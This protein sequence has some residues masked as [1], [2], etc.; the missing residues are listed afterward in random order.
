MIRV[1]D[2]A[3]R[4]EEAAGLWDGALCGY[5]LRW[6]EV[7]GRVDPLACP[8]ARECFRSQAIKGV[9]MKRFAWMVSAVLGIVMSQGIAHAQSGPSSYGGTQS[10]WNIFNRKNKSLT[11]E[12][13]RLNKFWHD[14]YDALKQYYNALD[15]I[16]WVA[17]YKNHGYRSPAATTA[18]TGDLATSTTPPSW[19]LP[20]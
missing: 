17:Y 11:P 9:A 20:R 6:Q 7:A 4:W 2:A 19:W 1:P 15:H 8:V 12:E 13:Q 3:C 16:D 18:P 14:Y 5:R 10:S